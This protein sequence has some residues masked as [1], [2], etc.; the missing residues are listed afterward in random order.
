MARYK[1]GLSRGLSLPRDWPDEP[2]MLLIATMWVPIRGQE[3]CQEKC[4]V[5]SFPSGLFPSQEGTRLRGRGQVLAF[6]QPPLDGAPTRSKES[7]S[8]ASLLC[9]PVSLDTFCL[10][11]L[12]GTQN[13]RGAQMG[14]NVARQASEQLAHHW[15]GAAAR[16]LLH[17]QTDSHSRPPLAPLSAWHQGPW[18]KR[19]ALQLLLWGSAS[20]Y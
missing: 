15:G 18:E 8:G 13:N 17:L 16:L 19:P 5:A 14:L 10:S 9:P 7:S 12:L 3:K 4:L 6:L 1:G 20:D 11:S 2:C